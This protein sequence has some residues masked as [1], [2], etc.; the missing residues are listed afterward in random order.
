MTVQSRL[1]WRR[2]TQIAHRWLGLGLA[3]QVL[4]W[5]ASGAFMSL[6]DM[7]VVRGGRTL[8]PSTAPMLEARRYF[9]PG[10]VI[11]AQGAVES[12]T[13][14]IWNGRP[15]Y[16][17]QTFAGERL[18]D[19]ATGEA[20]SPIG[21]AA[22]I[23]IARKSYLGEGDVVRARLLQEA[24]VDWRGELPVWRIDIDDAARTRVYVSPS[25]GEALAH[26]NALWRI[27]DFF[28]MLHIMDY[29]GRNDY[30]NPLIRIFSVCA[31]LFSI[32]GIAL[33]VNRLRSGRY[34][35]DAAALL[36][37]RSAASRE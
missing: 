5:M 15:V 6:V 30:S 31:V 17:V 18:F 36:K 29:D 10:G 20:L 14:K 32:T 2:W 12:I 4:L 37:R 28:W 26:R 11:A 16:V 8:A 25:T 35:E 3:V 33:V 34:P 19:A 9:P 1:R 22:A 7:D 13:L 21:E 27:Y 24:P 23:E